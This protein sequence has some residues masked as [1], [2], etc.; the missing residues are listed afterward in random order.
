MN[1]ELAVQLETFRAMLEAAQLARLTADGMLPDLAKIFSQGA[2]KV[3]RK[4]ANV[5]IG[6]DGHRSGRYMVDLAT[7]EIFGVKG[8]GVIH[9]GHG[10]GTLATIHRW[11][12]G[13]YTA[14]PAPLADK[15]NDR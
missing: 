5:D 15:E 4:Y 2:V 10:Y 3:G 8:Y 14:T 11:N 7:G 13:G 12:W 1:P 6:A 9:R